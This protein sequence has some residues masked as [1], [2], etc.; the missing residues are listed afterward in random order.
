MRVYIGPY[1]SRWISRVHERHMNIKYGSNDWDD[2]KDWE[3]R[4]WEKLESGLQSLYNA[5]INRYIDK[6]QRKIVIKLD[7]YDTWGMD[8]TLAYI[9]VPML[10]QLKATK[11]GSPNTDDEDVPE[12]LRSTTAPPVKKWY[13]DGN[14]HARWEWI[15]N[16]MIWAFE[17][18]T[19]DWWEE[20][21]IIE[22]GEIDFD[23]K[24]D[25]NGNTEL[26]WKKEGKYDREGQRAHQA[27]MSNG[28]RL[29]G[30]YYEALW[31]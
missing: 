5:T 18:K 2:S 27:R 22:H 26:K 31:D 11:H 6:K 8:H 13:E 15:L 12:H 24:P 21:Y 9:I 4:A 10:K 23:A 1:T 25:E 7:R 30:K 14:L 17:Q 28:F 3:D 20:D 29:F 16:E 19:R